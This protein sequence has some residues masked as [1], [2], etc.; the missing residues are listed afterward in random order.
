ML[1]KTRKKFRVICETREVV[2]DGKVY[3]VNVIDNKHS[4]A[5]AARFPNEVRSRPSRD[6]PTSDKPRGLPTDS[7]LRGDVRLQGDVK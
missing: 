5:V 7:R 3:K 1:R 4:E 6:K 2:R